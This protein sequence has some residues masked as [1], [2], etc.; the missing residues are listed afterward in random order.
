MRHAPILACSVLALMMVLCASTG[1]SANASRNIQPGSSYSDAAHYSAGDEI[2]YLWYCEDDLHFTLSSPT[3][4]ALVDEV[5]VSDAGSMEAAV[6]GDYT[7][8]WANEGTTTVN[9][10]YT[11]DILDNVEDALSMVLIIGIITVVI[12]VVIVIVVIVFILG[13]EKAK[14]SKT[15]PG[16]APF[17]PPPGGVGGTCPACGSTIAS[18]TSFCARCGIRIR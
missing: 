8:T 7:F 9:L 15:A 14:A 18:D 17:I 5:S 2:T 13:D 4:T 10:N 6:S 1:V 16:P 12:I 11:I 3:G